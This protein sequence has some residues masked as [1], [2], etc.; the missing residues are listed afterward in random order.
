MTEPDDAGH[1]AT[2]GARIRDL[3]EVRGLSLSELARR[4]GIGKA[5][6]SELEAGRR[7]PTLDTLYAL[8]APLGIGLSTLLLDGRPAAGATPV[9]HPEIAG[10]GIVATLLDALPGPQGAVVEVY[11]LVIEP[12]PPHRSP[13]HGPGVRE[14]LTLA[15][16]RAVVGPPGAEQ[17]IAA[18]DTA[19]WSSEGPH[20]YR[21]LDGDAAV[22]LL[23]ITC[24]AEPG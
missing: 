4:A 22:G 21:A 19:V 9:G 6:L 15:S 18:G 13:G 5:T 14:R 20:S 24:P 16:G 8:T 3:R 7:N 12:G 2:V 23:I 11:R 1:G 10:S 17:V